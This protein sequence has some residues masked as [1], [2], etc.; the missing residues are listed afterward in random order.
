MSAA[1]AEVP[2][3][4]ILS[5]GLNKK[6]ISPTFGHGPVSPA[7]KRV[8]E[9]MYEHDDFKQ[10]DLARKASS[11]VEQA[12]TPGSVLFSFPA[13]M[14]ANRFEAYKTI[15]ASIGATH[16]FRTLNLYQRKSIGGLLIEAK[17]VSPSDATKAIVTGFHFNGKVFRGALS[18][19]KSIREG[20]V[21]VNLNLLRIP[22]KETFL[23]DLKKSLRFYG[24][25]YQVKRYT[26]GG[27]FEGE[28]SVVLD[29]KSGYSAVD[30]ELVPCQPL[31]RMLYLSVWDTFVPAT[32][33]GAKRVC[34]FCRKAGHVVKN[35]PE[36]AKIKCYNCGKSGHTAGRCKVEKSD[37]ELLD[38]YASAS[39]Q[40]SSKVQVPVAITSSAQVVESELASV[41]TGI[42]GL[43]DGSVIDVTGIDGEDI[44]HGESK[45]VERSTGVNEDSG[46]KL[47]EFDDEEDLSDASGVESVD[48]PIHDK[49][50]QEY[51]PEREEMNLARPLA[52][53]VKALSKVVSKTGAMGDLKSRTVMK[54]KPL[55]NSK[56]NVARRV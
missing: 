34:N 12:L 30:G 50:M 24:E 40:G 54:K 11:I 4:T 21:H 7:L 8:A 45:V 13:G 14:F 49:Y 43:T 42:D 6:V 22:D 33:K 20:M 31:E 39:T 28:I 52:D 2:W 47:I 36:L 37:G 32:F 17:F 10:Q 25:V 35:C 9:V 46:S 3:T 56:S 19:D 1:T 15:Q 53:K 18:E 41:D 16:G 29:T 26:C 5:R 27:F 55:A 44:V 23:V 51:D 38:E 48:V